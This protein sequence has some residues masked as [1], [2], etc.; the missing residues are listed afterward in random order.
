[1]GTLLLTGGSTLVSQPPTRRGEDTDRG[2]RTSGVTGSIVRRAQVGSPRSGLK[3]QSASELGD[4]FAGGLALAIGTDLAIA[5][6]S[7]GYAA[8]NAYGTTY[9]IDAPPPETAS[10]AATTAA[11][12][13][14]AD[15]EATSTSS[16]TAA[17]ATTAAA[18]PA[19][20]AS[21]A[22]AT[23]TTA[24]SAA[25]SSGELN[26]RCEGTTSFRVKDAESSEAYV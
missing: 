2:T 7:P 1:M 4:V 24:T 10:C 16:A 9:A 21:T 11:A 23:T 8:A 15:K 25:A 22:S 18:S 20:P 17:R 3:V 12:A 5:A 6:T 14:P 26:T 13:T 19:S